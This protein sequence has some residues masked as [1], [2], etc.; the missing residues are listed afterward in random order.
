MGKTVRM[1]WMEGGQSPV[2]TCGMPMVGGSGKGGRWRGREWGHRRG[3]R[4]VE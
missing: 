2:S 4:V 3:G 1:G